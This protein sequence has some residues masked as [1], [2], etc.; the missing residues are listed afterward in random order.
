MLEMDH[1]GLGLAVL[2]REMKLQM[3]ICVDVCFYKLSMGKT[4]TSTTDNEVLVV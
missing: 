4:H 1:F 3:K 2:N